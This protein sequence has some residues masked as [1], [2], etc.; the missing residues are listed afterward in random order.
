MDSDDLYNRSVIMPSRYRQR[1]I[2][3]DN[4]YKTDDICW[5][6]SV[7]GITGKSSTDGQSE[8]QRARGRQRLTFLQS[9]PKI[10]CFRTQNV[11]WE[12]ASV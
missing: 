6:Y 7:E 1:I 9:G 10:V 3:A 2:D 8:G 12:M 4:N 11:H 5:T